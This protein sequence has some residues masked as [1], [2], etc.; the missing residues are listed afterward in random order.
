MVLDKLLGIYFG[1]AN[2]YFLLGFAVTCAVTFWV[3]RRLS[4]QRSTAFIGAAL[5]TFTPYHF[6][7]MMYGHTYYTWYFV[8]PLYIYLGFKVFGLTG[9]PTKSGCL[10]TMG[11]LV[12]ASCFGVYFAFFGVIAIMICGIA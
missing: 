7:R 10:K 6:A 12:L 8:V 4:L 3:M 11:T 5:F 1:E 2:A 9:R